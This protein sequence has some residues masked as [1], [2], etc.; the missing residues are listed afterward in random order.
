YAVTFFNARRE[1]DALAVQVADYA[2]TFLPN[3][4]LACQRAVEAF[5]VFH[6]GYKSLRQTDGER[7]DIKIELSHYADNGSGVWGKTTTTMYDSSLA[8]QACAD[9]EISTPPIDSIKVT[10]N[11]KYS[12]A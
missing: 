3:P 9:G 8:G 12:F 4:T 11:A 2:S 7:F 5:T 10:I 1:L 6:S